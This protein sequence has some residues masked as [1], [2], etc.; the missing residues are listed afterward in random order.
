MGP[1][2]GIFFLLLLV[3]GV[4]G[5]ST[6]DPAQLQ[7]VSSMNPATDPNGCDQEARSNHVQSIVN[8][9][10]SS[11]SSNGGALDKVNYVLQGRNMS[12]PANSCAEIY[13]INSNSPSGYYWLRNQ[14]G[15]TASRVYCDM[16]I[17]ACGCSTQRG[18]IRLGILDMDDPATECPSQWR[19]L[20]ANGKRACG[21][22]SGGWSWNA[23]VFEVNGIPYQRVCGKIIGYVYGSPDAFNRWGSQKWRTVNDVYFDGADVVYGHF[24]HTINKLQY[25][26]IWSYTAAFNDYSNFCPC[27]ANSNRPVPTF[28]GNNN[29]YCE[30]G[31]TSWGWSATMKTDD[32]LWDGMTCRGTEGPC[33]TTGAPRFCR[34]LNSPVSDNIYIRLMTDGGQNDE[35]IPIR[36]Y[37]L[38]VQ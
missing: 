9:L 15:G 8:S 19:F 33:C 10:P 31:G 30:A 38:Y 7:H 12:N 23:Q 35:D 34:S 22:T 26:H 11:L 2:S 16:D 37:E 32:P 6:L 4:I 17:T 18:W 21:K 29:Y 20:S 36:Y 13:N 28:V 1:R 25:S 14:N 5:Q 27:A 3:A 24:D